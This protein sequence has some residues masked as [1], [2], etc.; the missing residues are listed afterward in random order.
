MHLGAII[1]SL[2]INTCLVLILFYFQKRSLEQRIKHLKKEISEL[3]DL[4]AAII[5][6]FEA[7]SE[8]VVTNDNSDLSDVSEVS[9]VAAQSQLP[10]K[11]E[12]HPLS[13]Q[14]VNFSTNDPRHENIMDMW[15]QGLSTEEI[16]KKMG[17]GQGEIKLILG[18][19]HRG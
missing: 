17:T 18:L 9:V 8:A 1:L 4:V 11:T 12:V 6:E 16:A 14:V 3:E 7:V 15:Q 10:N 19:Y 5:E 13:R 2:I